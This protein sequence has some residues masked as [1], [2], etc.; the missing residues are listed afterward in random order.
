MATAI[1][2]LDKAIGKT[3]GSKLPKTRK[4]SR[5]SNTE[6]LVVVKLDHNGGQAALVF[7]VLE[8][9]GLLDRVS[10]HGMD[11]VEPGAVGFR[12]PRERMDAVVLALECGGFVN[13]RAFDVQEG[14]D[15]TERR[16]EDDDHKAARPQTVH[17]RKGQ[18]K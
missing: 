6:S 9:A 1:Q 8:Q 11:M 2:V 13:V 3:S 4:A 15:S 7:E 17:A 16:K 12:I 10:E 18:K 5:V 14:L